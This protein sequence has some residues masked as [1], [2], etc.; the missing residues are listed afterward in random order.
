MQLI[1]NLKLKSI[2]LS[3]DLKANWYRI[4]RRALILSSRCQSTQAPPASQA[5][6]AAH[7]RSR[8]CYMSRCN[9]IRCIRCRPSISRAT[10]PQFPAA[11]VIR[12][13][14]V[15]SWAATPA[16]AAIAW[17]YTRRPWRMPPSS[18]RQAVSATTSNPP[19]WHNTIS[20]LLQSSTEYSSLSSEHTQQQPSSSSS[21]TVAT[22]AD[23]AESSGTDW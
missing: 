8:A 13:W 21:H 17:S 15:K 10:A 9:S 4:C 5:A 23:I 7:R 20:N 12:Q 6:A 1:W 3:A 22:L 19:M 2:L 18:Q 16:A 11:T 14:M